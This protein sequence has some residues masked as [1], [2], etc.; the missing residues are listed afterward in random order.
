MSHAQDE[1]FGFLA[2]G[3]DTIEISYYLRAK[4]K[5]DLDFTALIAA[6]DAL[7]RKKGKA[8]KIVRLGSEEFLLSN[9]GTSAG[10]SLFM[11]NQAFHIAFGELIQPNFYVK[12]LSQALWHDGLDNLH[13]RFL[14]WAASV[15][16]CPFKPESL[17][18][19]DFAFDYL[20]PHRD[21]DQDSFNSVAVSDRQHRKRGKYQTFDFGSGDAK[22][23]V[24]HKSDE[25]KDASGKVWFYPIWGGVV[26]DVW[27]IEWQFRKD[28]LRQ[29]GICSLDDLNKRQGDLLR[30]HATTHTSLRVKG[31]AE[32][33][34]DCPLHSLWQDY[35]N[36]IEQMPSIGIVREFDANRVSEE[37]M[38]RLLISVLGYMKRIA[39]LQC[40]KQNMDHMPLG[41]ALF[42]LRQRLLSLYDPLD[43]EDGVAQRIREMGFQN[44]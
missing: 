21:F 26:D 2:S 40:V 32:D 18:R 3:I 25:I 11:E 37:R 7:R 9:H 12:C 35:L 23:R 16:L 43:W 36:R 29:I 19:L 15:G 8:T 20:I 24:Y 33:I 4:G 44:D 1:P 13:K 6:R 22:L 31:V 10:Y 41:S 39:A 38:L 17:S 27:R 28:R 30:N 42:F 34:K 14:T 5:C